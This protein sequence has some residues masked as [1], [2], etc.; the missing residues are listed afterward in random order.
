M[1]NPVLSF[2]SRDWAGLP[3]AAVVALL[4][5]WCLRV[6]RASGGTGAAAVGTALLVVAGL[7]ALGSVWHLVHVA[8]TRALHPPPGRLVDVGGYR[9][10]VV[11]EGESG[12]SP[13]SSGWPG[14][15][16]AASPST[17]FIGC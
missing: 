4:G 2:L 7:L 16:W 5:G 17:T 12:G 9:M 10:H 14:G 6:G 15:T 3:V 1:G 8:R 11:A 13:R